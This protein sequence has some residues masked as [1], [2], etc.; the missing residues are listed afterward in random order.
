MLDYLK[1]FVNSGKSAQLREA[2]AAVYS[3]WVNSITGLLSGLIIS[4]IPWVVLNALQVYMHLT[5]AWEIGIGQ[6]DVRLQTY[7]ASSWKLALVLGICG[8]ICANIRRIAARKNKYIRF[9]VG[10]DVDFCMGYDVVAAIILLPVTLM[11]V[12]DYARSVHV[13]TFF[14][15]FFIGQIWVDI[16]N[17]LL[18]IYALFSRDRGPEVICG[19]W[20]L[21]QRREQA[22]DAKIKVVGARNKGKTVFLIGEFSS[23]AAEYLQNLPLLIDGVKEVKLNPTD[24]DPKKNYQ[25]S[26]RIG[27]RGSAS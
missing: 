5:S 3:P 13:L 19:V 9:S 27:A 1:V 18:G 22:V 7:L 20:D 25:I 16:Q 17:T 2:R 12:F 6:T 14:F 4:L 21:L 10:Y 24:I 8:I 15:S 11:L 26:Q 23:E